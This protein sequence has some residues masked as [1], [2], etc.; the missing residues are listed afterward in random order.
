[1]FVNAGLILFNK[2][3]PIYYGLI[4]FVI[5]LVF[6]AGLILIAIWA[7]KDYA[8]SRTCLIIGS[9]LILGATISLILWNLLFLYVFDKK[10]KESI[11]IG[12]GDDPDDYTEKSKG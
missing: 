11:W 6:L 7:C 3:V 2:R 9:W 8:R 12:S 10:H 5:A 1:V 4:S